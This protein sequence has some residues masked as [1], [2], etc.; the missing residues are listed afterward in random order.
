MTQ[1]TLFL[2]NKAYS[3]WSL[4]GW[5]ACKIAGLDFREEIH[6]MGA[7]DWKTW[8][9]ARSPTGKVPCLLI[10]GAS[11]WESLAIGDFLADSAPAKFWPQDKAARAQARSIAAEMHAGFVELRKAMWMNVRARF[12]GKGRT[13]G[14]LND[15]ARIQGLWAE[16]RRKFGAGGPYLF[17][18]QFGMADA[19]YAPVVARFVT[20]AP[21]LTKDSAAYVDA[22][23]NH[24]YMK[25]WLAAATAEKWVLEKYE[26]AAD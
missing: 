3:S 21:D 25:E 19:M 4:R 11:V 17:G 20:W 5:L 23:W 15:I 8:I 13:P 22:V 2:G 14:A 16:S 6:D 1:A 24:P 12:P 10:D 7:P 18:A 26:T 9:A